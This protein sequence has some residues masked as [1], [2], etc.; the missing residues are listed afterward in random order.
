MTHSYT[1]TL[2]DGEM[3]LGTWDAL[4]QFDDV[5]VGEYVPPPEP[6]SGTL[7]I[8]EDFEDGAA[9]FFQTRLG[10]WQVS[11]GRY[12]VTPFPGGDA[13]STLRIEGTLPAD[14]DLQATVNIE[15]PS[16]GR[17]NNALLIFDYQDDRDFKFAGAYAGTDRWVIGHRNDSGWWTDAYFLQPVD[18]ATDYQL[19]LVIEDDHEVTLYVDGLGRVTHSYTD[20]LSD[21][22]VGLGT[23]N[24][25]AQFD[26]VVVQQYQES[27]ATAAAIFFDSFARYGGTSERIANAS[28]GV[29]GHDAATLLRGELLDQPLKLR[30]YVRDFSQR[31]W[32][33]LVDQVLAGFKGSP[34]RD[35]LEGIPSG[36]DLTASLHELLHEWDI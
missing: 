14:L 8:G 32:S 3:G 20:T 25:L 29:W 30:P 21:G 27:S 10:A 33:E 4:A 31:Q 22:E 5:W 13:V 19:Q 24:A 15:P 1:D 28:D 34:A 6:P 26:D 7:P 35:R 16:G 18:V 12:H 11:D 2:S 23:W 36:Y 9:D 17:Y